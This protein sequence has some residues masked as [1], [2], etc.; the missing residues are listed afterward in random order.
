MKIRI[1][2]KSMGVGRGELV[3]EYKCLNWDVGSLG[4]IITFNG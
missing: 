2:V 4:D 1:S 3:V